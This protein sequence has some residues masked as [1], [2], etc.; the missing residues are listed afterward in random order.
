LP[1]PGNNRP[2]TLSG[3]EPGNAPAH[4]HRRSMTTIA[5]RLRRFLRSPQGRRLA[6]QAQELAAR[7]ENRRRLQQWGR[8][9]DRR[10]GHR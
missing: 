7:P 3:R 5:E 1:E 4:C 6:R 9:L 8:R 10:S 2:P